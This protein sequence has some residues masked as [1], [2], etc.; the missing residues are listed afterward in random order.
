MTKNGHSRSVLLNPKAKAVLDGLRERKEM[1]PLTRDSRF[2]SPA[3][4]GASLGHLR[5]LHV[6]FE[7]VCEAANIDG[8]RIHDLRQS[9]AT[10]AVMRGASLYDVQKLLGHADIGMTQRYAHM[11]DDSLQRAT[12]N[13]S[14]AIS[15]AADE[16]QPTG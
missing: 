16:L 11:V 9:F 8:L 15:K 6:S 14:Q 7:K 10:I 13:L 2:V 1:T 3:R 4:D 12:D 5:D